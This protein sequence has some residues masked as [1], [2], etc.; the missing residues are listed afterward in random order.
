[1][2]DIIG[3]QFKS[4]GKEY[5]FD[6]KDIVVNPGDHVVV[7][8]SRGLEFGL[9]PRGNRKMNK[10]RVPSPLRPLI[11]IATNEDKRVV[12][13]NKE[14][15][16]TAFQACESKIAAHKLE[17]KLVTAEYSFEGNKVLFFFTADGRVDFRGLVR[18]LAS[19]LHARIELRQIGVRDEAKMIGGL[20]ACG[21]PFCCSEFL[22]R[23]M[24]VSI[25]M[26]KTQN[27]SLNPTKISGTCGR[28]MCC[29]KYEQAAYEDLVKR[30]PRSDS[31][32][33]TPD[34]AGIVVTVG[35]LREQVRVKLENTMD[36]PKKYHNSEIVVIRSGKGKRPEGYVQ[37]P[38]AELEKLR[39]IEEK[40]VV[41][42]YTTVNPLASALEEMLSGSAER[43]EKFNQMKQAE[44]NKK[45]RP[46][47]GQ[48]QRK[49]R[50]AEDNNNPKTQK[51]NRNRNHRGK[52]KRPNPPKPTTEN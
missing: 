46:P 45:R 35:L 20:G 4:G 42:M 24:P 11:R 14:R 13:R 41:E 49:P 44:R 39:R 48:Q 28:L 8:T 26:A 10:E 32:V 5:F 50:V 21:R 31:F 36:P 19:A 22:D 29:L 9:C 43:E 6:P 3:V 15:E 34:G 23:F 30:A 33:E 2:T 18:D 27:L 52:G 16:K 37:P 47:Q 17:M 1:M 40:K 38:L 25:K 7:E 12:E 51:P